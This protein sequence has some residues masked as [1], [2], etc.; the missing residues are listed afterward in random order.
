M[1][2]AQLSIQKANAKIS[3]LRGEISDLR[4]KLNTEPDPHKRAGME[5]EI[6]TNEQAIALGESQIRDWQR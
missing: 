5:Q 4:E 1:F 6:R 2:D 3:R